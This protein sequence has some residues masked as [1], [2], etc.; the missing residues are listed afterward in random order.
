MSDVRQSDTDH[1]LVLDVPNVIARQVMKMA[2]DRKENMNTIAGEQ[3]Y[4]GLANQ[5]ERALADDDDTYSAH[6]VRQSDR[7]YHLVLDVPVAVVKQVYELA[8]ERKEAVNT[9]AGEQRYGGLANQIERE[10]DR[11]RKTTKAS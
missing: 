2:R 11:E 1:H 9:K 5:I 8:Q 4:G 7:D 6:N 3:R 10:L